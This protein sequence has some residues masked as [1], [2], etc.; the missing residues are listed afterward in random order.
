M[1]LLWAVAHGLDATSKRMGTT[2][3][4]TGPQRLVLR[5]VGRQ[6][7]IAAG[8]LAERL[9]LHPSTLTGVVARLEERGVLRRR[10]DPH[11]ARRLLLELTEKGQTLDV[12]HPGTVEAAVERA[13]GP[14]T[15]EELGVATKV[16]TAISAALAAVDRDE[17][18]VS[19]VGGAPLGP[20]SGSP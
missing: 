11:D 16:L 1:R 12:P 17:A 13:L 15:E 2:I 20:T 6:P 5:F 9:F 7:G 8:E 3:G 19:P 4:L 14:I 10:R 18:E